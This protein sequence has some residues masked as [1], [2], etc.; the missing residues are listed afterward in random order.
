MLLVVLTTYIY[1]HVHVHIYCTCIVY[2]GPDV[3]TCTCTLVP[4]QCDKFPKN[5]RNKKYTTQGYSQT[6]NKVTSLLLPH[7]HLEAPATLTV[8]VNS[9]E[10]T[11]RNTPLFSFYTSTLK[12]TQPLIG[13]S[14]KLCC[15]TCGTVC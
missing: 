11:V 5:K 2:T 3:R 8:T 12:V 9:G 10:P 6:N 7:I 13:P 4:K 1:V 15:Q 14:L